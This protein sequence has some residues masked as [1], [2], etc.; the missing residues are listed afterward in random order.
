MQ[1]RHLAG[2]ASPW[3]ENYPGSRF[4]QGGKTVTG[5]ARISPA[6]HYPGMIG[7]TDTQLG[8]V[9]DAARALPVEKRGLYL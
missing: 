1:R 5:F 3:R 6:R 4:Q 7:L 9:M 2:G 8:T